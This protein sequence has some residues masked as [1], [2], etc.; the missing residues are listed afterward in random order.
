MEQPHARM[1]DKAQS[2][3]HRLLELNSFPR[4]LTSDLVSFFCLSV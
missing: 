1:F 3:V 4:F 2:E